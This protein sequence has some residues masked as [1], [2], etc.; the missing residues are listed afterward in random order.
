[1]NSD[2]TESGSG[3]VTFAAGAIAT[4]VVVSVVNDAEA[5]RL[6]AVILTITPD[7]AYNVGSPSTGSATIID[8]NDDNNDVLVRYIFTDA[9]ST[10]ST[11]SLAPQV[12]STNVSATALSAV[13]ITL[14]SSSFT[15]SPPNAG[16]I[17]SSSTSSNQ[18]EAIANNDYFSF[19]LT[20]TIGHSLTLTN[21]ELSARYY[22]V[23]TLATEAS[24]FVRSSLDDF[25]SDVGSNSFSFLNLYSAMSIPLGA[26][27][28]QIPSNITFRVY[29]FDDTTDATDGIRIDDIFVRGSIDTL[30]PTVITKITVGGSAPGSSVT[31]DFTAGASDVPAAFT[32]EKATTVN[33]VYG[34]DGGAVISGNP[35]APN[36]RATTTTTPPKQ[37]FYRIRR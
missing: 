34:A 2:Y 10:A 23:N 24:V 27:F 16:S 17:P 8:D 5:E 15:V 25:A 37:G 3:S 11:F 36:F 7:A 30:P 33:G 31:I 6:E 29:V 12:Y 13:G 26:S 14:G 18:T 19:T 20:P 4:N 21:L 32:L 35:S 9:N 28:T 22:V 1:L